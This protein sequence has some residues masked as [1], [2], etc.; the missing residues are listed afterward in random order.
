MKSRGFSGPDLLRTFFPPLPAYDLW[1]NDCSVACFVATVYKEPSIEKYVL[2]LDF[3]AER[4]KLDK[5]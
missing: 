5:K 4:H 2:D 3:L 1:K